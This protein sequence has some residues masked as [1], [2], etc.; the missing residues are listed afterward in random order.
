MSQ[1][2]NNEVARLNVAITGDVTQLAA[3][4]KQGEQ[5][6][7][8]SAA[9]IE[10]IAAATTASVQQ[11]GGTGPN[12]A[13]GFGI[14]GGNTFSPAGGGGATGG[15]GILNRIGQGAKNAMQ[16]VNML[17]GVLSRL[18]FVFGLLAAAGGGF[19]AALTAGERETRRSAEA[20]A[21]LKKNLDGVYASFKLNLEKSP[22]QVEAEALDEVERK[23]A[24]Q[25]AAAFARF[26]S[27]EMKAKDLAKF[28]EDNEK[29]ADKARDNVRRNRELADND[30]AAKS[31]QAQQARDEQAAR[32]REDLQAKMAGGYAEVYMNAEAE[33]RRAGEKL[34]GDSL[35]AKV[36]TIEFER[37]ER[38][39]AMS[40][41]AKKIADEEIAQNKRVHTEKERLMREF[42][43]SSREAQAEGT[44]VESFFAGNQGQSFGL[45]GRQ[46]GGIDGQL[47]S[48][49]YQGAE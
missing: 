46:R 20:L 9:K 42:Y 39:R 41:A 12:V 40:D 26:K 31:Q 18:S 5:V 33:I 15:G 6:V 22:A 16:P 37:N 44:M 8:Q 28:R 34:S 17:L 11:M 4:A 19:Y 13:S 48:I 23:R 43:R 27:G 49:N 36:A 32:D 21:D 1:G 2:G 3:A 30:A 38:I 35:D 14:F 45:A 7:Q 25:D 24:E 10:Q 47:P 29:Q